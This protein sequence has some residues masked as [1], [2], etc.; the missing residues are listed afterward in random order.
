MNC[1]QCGET[2]DIQVRRD[3]DGEYFICGCCGFA[4]DN[5]DDEAKEGK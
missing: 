4:F 5:N 1:S 2:E 3:S